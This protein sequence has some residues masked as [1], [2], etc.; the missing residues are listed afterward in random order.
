MQTLDRK[1]G[2]LL[3]ASANTLKV[4]LFPL[5][6]EDVQQGELRS[7]IIA[8]PDDLLEAQALLF[9]IDTCIEDEGHT[10]SASRAKVTMSS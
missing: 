1:A 2:H 8:A 10:E 6:A 9:G 3:G 5:T 7:A 4:A